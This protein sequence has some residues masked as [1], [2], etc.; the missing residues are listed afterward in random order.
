MAQ[1]WCSL[2][3]HC[4]VAMVPLV[5]QRHPGT[6]CWIDAVIPMS[7]VSVRERLI[8]SRRLPARENYC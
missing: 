6:V 8:E 3:W 5:E 1:A 4:R 7:S 2:L